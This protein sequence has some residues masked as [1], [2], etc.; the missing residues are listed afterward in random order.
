[1]YQTDPKLSKGLTSALTGLTRIVAE[2]H[3]DNTTP[4]VAPQPLVPQNQSNYKP[5]NCFNC[6]AAGHYSKNCQQPKKNSNKSPQFAN[7]QSQNQQNPAGGCSTCNMTNH[8]DATCIWKSRGLN[9]PVC[10]IC[11]KKGHTAQKCWKNKNNRPQGPPKYT[12]QRSN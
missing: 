1:V 12:N 11:S 8:T 5:F 3:K 10:Q 4:S 7:Q 9:C 2:V 6:G